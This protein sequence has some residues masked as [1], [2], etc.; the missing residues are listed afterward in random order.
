MMKILGL[1]LVL[2]CL[3]SCG[4]GAGA[5]AGPGIRLKTYWPEIGFDRYDAVIFPAEPIEP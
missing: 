2:L 3:T 4:A 1:W 5:V